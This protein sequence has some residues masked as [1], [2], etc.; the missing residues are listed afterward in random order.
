MN[1]N[2]LESGNVRDIF[3][4]KIYESRINSDANDPLNSLEFKWFVQIPDEFVY[5]HRKLFLRTKSFRI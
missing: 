3:L 2:L 1:P 5:F 4:K